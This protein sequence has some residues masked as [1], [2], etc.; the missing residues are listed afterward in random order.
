MLPA[1]VKSLLGMTLV[2]SVER[3]CEARVLVG[4]LQPQPGV[5]V[6]RKHFVRRGGRSKDTSAL[7]VSHFG[8]PVMLVCR[9]AHSNRMRHLMLFLAGLA[10][11]VSGCSAQE[12]ALRLIQTGLKLRDAGALQHLSQAVLSSRRML[13]APVTKKKGGHHKSPPIA[14]KRTSPPIAKKSI[15]PPIAKKRAPPPQCNQAICLSTKFLLGLPANVLSLKSRCSLFSRTCELQPAVAFILKYC[16]L[17]NASQCCAKLAANKKTG[18]P[19][20]VQTANISLADMVACT[21]L[22]SFTKLIQ[23]ELQHKLAIVKCHQ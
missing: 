15:S 17:P 11:A 10:C 6:E 4:C 19:P 14:K 21:K 12:A 3:G 2:A 9:A 8:P 5:V 23:L 16:L 1:A 18:A 7:T 20:A 13:A 22:P